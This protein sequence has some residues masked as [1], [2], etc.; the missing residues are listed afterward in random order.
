MNRRELLTAAIAI[1]ISSSL[2]FL[3]QV[4]AQEPNATASLLQGTTV[5]LNPASGAD[6]N[7]GAKAVPFAHWRRR[8]NW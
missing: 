3:S 6:T 2:V 7:S 5:Y 8:R 4:S 1:A